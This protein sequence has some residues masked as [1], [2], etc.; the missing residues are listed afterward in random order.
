[1]VSPF[2]LS[3]SASRRVWQ[4][5]A[6]REDGAVTASQHGH[7]HFRGIISGRSTTVRRSSARVTGF[8]AK[9]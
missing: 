4:I 3:L 6:G 9:I 1:M 5:H 2:L 8:Y 7:S